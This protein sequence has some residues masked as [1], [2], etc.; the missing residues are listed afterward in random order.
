MPKFP[1]SLASRSQAAAP[2]DPR[3]ERALRR[4]VLVGFGGGGI[5]AGRYGGEAGGEQGMG[6][7]RHGT[8]PASGETGNASTRPGGPPAGGRAAIGPCSR[9]HPAADSGSAQLPVCAAQR[10]AAAT[11]LWS[12]PPT[13]LHG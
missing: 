7:L 11:R 4:I 1:E 6:Q 2:I 10:L 5:A 9:Q 12:R 8:V 13:V 3:L